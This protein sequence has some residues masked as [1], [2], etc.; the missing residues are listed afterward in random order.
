MMLQSLDVDV[1]LAG[2]QSLRDSNH[3]SGLIGDGQYLGLGIECR[4]EGRGGMRTAL[5]HACILPAKD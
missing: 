5:Q 4:T 2:D 3:S 1:T